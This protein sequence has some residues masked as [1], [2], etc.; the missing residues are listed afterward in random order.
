VRIGLTTVYVDDQEQARRFYTE[1]LGMQLKEDALYGATER[2]LTVVAPDDP[3]GVALA[4]YQADAAARA[5]QQA[6]RAAGRPVLAFRTADCQGD[7]Q[8][9]RAKGAVFTLPPTR[10]EYGGLDAVLDDTCGNLLAL[11]Q[12]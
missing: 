8:R 7:Y 9:L 2:W 5:F 1:V 3:H 6:R 4:L 10:M 11:H 12:D